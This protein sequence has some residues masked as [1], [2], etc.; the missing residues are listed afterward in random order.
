[1]SHADRIPGYSDADMAA[2]D[3]IAA[4]NTVTNQAL[5][6]LARAMLDSPRQEKPRQ[7]RSYRLI[8][9]ARGTDGD[10]AADVEYSDG[11]RQRFVVR[12]NAN[13]DLEGEFEDGAAP[14]DVVGAGCR[15]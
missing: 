12:R 4:A 15:G 7:P 3:A 10:L 2:I 8:N 5:Q 14:D 13:G 11:R 1:M 6:E 9:V